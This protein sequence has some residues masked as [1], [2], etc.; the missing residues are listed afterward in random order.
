MLYFPYEVSK[1]KLNN[2][3]HNHHHCH[4]YGCIHV[5]G[6]VV[7]HN[8]D[9]QTHFKSIQFDYIKIKKLALHPEQSSIQSKRII[10]I[11]DLVNQFLNQFKSSRSLNEKEKSIQY[12]A[13]AFMYKE[14]CNEFRNKITEMVKFIKQSINRF[15]K[16]I[17]FKFFSSI[18]NRFSGDLDIALNDLNECIKLSTTKSTKSTKTTTTSI[19]NNN[20]SITSD[21]YYYFKADTLFHLNRKQESIDTYNEYLNKSSIDA[22]WRM[23]SY[24]TI[25]HLTQLHSDLILAKESESKSL[26]CFL[27]WLSSKF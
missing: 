15:P 20:N 1:L 18:Y 17:I 8:D 2:N 16:E 25:A 11:L 23:E 26:Y 7:Y 3:N 10:E 19:N 9:H 21:I 14:L 12:L 27:P 4:S 6:K 22:R 24:Y 13:D 5:L